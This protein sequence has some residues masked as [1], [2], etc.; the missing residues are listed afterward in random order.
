MNCP[1]C[2]SPVAMKRQKCEKCGQDLKIY[3]KILH[4][5]NYYYNVGLEKAKVRDLTGAILVLKKS[6]ELNKK[7]INARNLLGLVYF[8]SGE[9]VSALSE[10]V[11]SKHFQP[12]DND[13]DAYMESVQKNA[14]KLET[15]NQTIKKYNGALQSA[16]TGS[17]DLAIIQLKKVVSLNPHF[18]RALQLLALLYPIL[19]LCDILMK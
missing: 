19:P 1:K 8:E 11:I 3:K 9:T 13:A 7:N 17:E 12:D 16:K 5:S 2:N 6:L 14:T 15:L 18:I 4:L 10:W